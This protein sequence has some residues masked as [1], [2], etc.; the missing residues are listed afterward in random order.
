MKNP[1]YSEKKYLSGLIK[2][3]TVIS[4]DQQDKKILCDIEFIWA[5]V[6]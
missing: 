5:N 6:N 1:L 4:Y 3:K 2:G